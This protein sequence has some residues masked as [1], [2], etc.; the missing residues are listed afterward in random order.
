MSIVSVKM[1]HSV[2]VYCIIPTKIASTTHIQKLTIPAEIRNWPG[3]GLNPNHAHIWSTFGPT[4]FFF[5]IILI[6][7]KTAEL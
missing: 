2:K 5:F 7:Q 4:F 1:C 3:P 6:E